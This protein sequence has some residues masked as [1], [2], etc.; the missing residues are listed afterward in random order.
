VTGEGN[1][2]NQMRDA[3][4]DSGSTSRWNK[5]VL[6][7]H[8]GDTLHPSTRRYWEA[9]ASWVSYTRLSLP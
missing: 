4:H 8:G 5:S 7:L 9:I 2:M 1:K 3:Q 6:S